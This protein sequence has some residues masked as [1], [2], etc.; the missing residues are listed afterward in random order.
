MNDKSKILDLV[1][2]KKHNKA[3]NISKDNDEL[4]SYFISLLS[5]NKDSKNAALFV[6]KNNKNVKDFDK[7]YERLLKKTVRYHSNTDDW[8]V[9][10]LKFKNNYRLL[11]IYIEDILYKNKI[12]EAYSIIFRNPKVVDYIENKN[13]YKENF[14][15][16]ELLKNKYLENDDYSYLISSYEYA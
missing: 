9:I 16:Y 11:A 4:F 12:N 6:L 10:E 3:Y 2:K 1:H 5:T 15:D 8:D 7:L 14:S 13:N